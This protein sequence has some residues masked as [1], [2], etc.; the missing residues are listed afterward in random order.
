[1]S[2]REGMDQAVEAF[3]V[4]IEAANNPKSRIDLVPPQRDESGKTRIMLEISEQK[5]D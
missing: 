1:M 4:I 2:V 5:D 3:K